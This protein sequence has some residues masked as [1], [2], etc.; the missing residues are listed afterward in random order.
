MDSDRAGD[1]QPAQRGGRGD[2]GETEGACRP[3][4]HLP[5]LPGP[6]QG[7]RRQRGLWAPACSCPWTLPRK[8]ELPQKATASGSAKTP[9]TSA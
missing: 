8:D 1:P 2:H 7:D 5:P 9:A 3:R 6:L 4:Q